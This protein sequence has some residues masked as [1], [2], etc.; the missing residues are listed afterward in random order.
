MICPPITAY[1]MHSRL[2]K[3]KLIIVERSGHSMSEKPIEKELL[4]AM[5]KLI[6]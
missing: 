2:P 6:K 5:Q 3:S 1:R 4:K